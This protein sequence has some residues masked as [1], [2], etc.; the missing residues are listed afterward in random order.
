MRCSCK[1]RKAREEI[2]KTGARALKRSE[3]EA[4]RCPCQTSYAY[5]TWHL[6]RIRR[7]YVHYLRVLVRSLHYV[8]RRSPA[9]GIEVLHFSISS[10]S[11]KR[12]RHTR[13]FS[14]LTF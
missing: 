14:I 5:G 7:S 10:P 8:S 13:V 11:K 6:R 3:G 9:V 1:Y 4:E 12:F 2:R